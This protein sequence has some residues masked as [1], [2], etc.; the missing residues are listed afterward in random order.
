VLLVDVVLELVAAVLAG[1]AVRAL[2][3]GLAS[4]L[5]RH[6]AHEVAARVVAARAIRTLV[7]LLSLLGVGAREVGRVIAREYIVRRAGLLVLH[8]RLRSRRR[9]LRVLL[10]LLPRGARLHVFQYCECFRRLVHLYL[11]RR[12]DR[13]L[14]WLN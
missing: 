13:I 3:L 5:Q 2:V 14:R 11:A 8:F 6:V 9:L 10:R 12:H 1:A 4:A 7:P